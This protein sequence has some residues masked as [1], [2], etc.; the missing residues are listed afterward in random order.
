MS[1]A[2]FPSRTPNP[3]HLGSEWGA[4]TSPSSAYSCHPGCQPASLLSVQPLL[5]F[6][7]RWWLTRY[8][9]E[10]VWLWERDSCILLFGSFGKKKKDAALQ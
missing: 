10:L 4:V 6:R 8:W 7:V 3:L 9:R 2:L 1:F 5:P